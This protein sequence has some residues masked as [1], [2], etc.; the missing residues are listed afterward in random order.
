MPSASP[1]HSIAAHLLL[2][3]CKTCP[4]RTV[5]AELNEWRWWAVNNVPEVADLVGPVPT[6]ARPPARVPDDPVA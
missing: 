6:P 1:G 5:A 3:W 2:G 4:G